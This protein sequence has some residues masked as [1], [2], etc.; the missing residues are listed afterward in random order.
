MSPQ[1]PKLRNPEWSDEDDAAF[2]A[3]DHGTGESSATI[4]GRLG[5]R[6]TQPAQPE[7]DE[8]EQPPTTESAHAG[9]EGFQDEGQILDLPPEKKAE[10]LEA[11]SKIRDTLEGDQT[12]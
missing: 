2:E 12:N 8:P 11:I 4:R 9:H 7:V 6:A 1:A 10:D 5:I 3:Q